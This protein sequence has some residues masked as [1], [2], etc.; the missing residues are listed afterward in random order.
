MSTLFIGFLI[1]SVCLISY[2]WYVTF[3]VMNDL[4]IFEE[5]DAE[6]LLQDF[7]NGLRNTR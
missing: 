5:E 1:G 6:L 4:T 7:S 3:S 2:G